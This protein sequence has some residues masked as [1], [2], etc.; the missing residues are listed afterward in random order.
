MG[1]GTSPSE[2]PLDEYLLN[3][4]L[5]NTAAAGRFLLVKMHVCQATCQSNTITKPN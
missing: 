3:D 5:E 1:D 4:D 2:V